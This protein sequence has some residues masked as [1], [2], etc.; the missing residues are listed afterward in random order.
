MDHTHCKF[1]IGNRFTFSPQHNSLVD[2]LQPEETV[3]LG[4]NESRALHLLLDEPGT[5]ISRQRM[6]DFIW[7]EQGFEVDDSSLTQSI[8]TLRKYLQDSTRSPAFIKTIP[9][10]GYQ[11][12]ASVDR[13][14]AATEPTIETP[15]GEQ[16]DNNDD[17]LD[18]PAPFSVS[19]NLAEDTS[20]TAPTEPESQVTHAPVIRQLF[21][22]RDMIS[23][24]ATFILCILLP[25]WA[26][27]APHPHPVP[28]I[29]P[30]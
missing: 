27:L 10:R 8:S 17:F 24:L 6:H 5:I 13:I 9:K 26:Y 7:R 28:S 15:T 3:Y 4:I 25:F 11:M 20:D 18:S 12:I 21:Q 19:E 29:K 22:S 2:N 1:L 23:A 14:D 30:L 16:T